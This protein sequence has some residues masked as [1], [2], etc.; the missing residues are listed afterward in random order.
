MEDL[1]PCAICGKFMNNS[2]IHLCG[3]TSTLIHTC[4]NCIE[5]KVCG[6]DK[7]DVINKWNTFVFVTKR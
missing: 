5:I 4:L 3:G 1:K 7:Y 2:A 6:R